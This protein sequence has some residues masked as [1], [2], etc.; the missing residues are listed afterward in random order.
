MRTSKGR[1]AERDGIRQAHDEKET[2]VYSMAYEN[3]L[4]LGAVSAV[5][6]DGFAP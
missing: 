1:L 5:I 2:E 4:A 3:V 6:S